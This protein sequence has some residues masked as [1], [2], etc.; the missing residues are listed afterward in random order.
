M[1]TSESRTVEFLDES[2]SH[3]VSVVIPS[4]DGRLTIRRALDSLIP[5][6]RWIREVILVFSNSPDEFQAFARTL[7][8]DYES[9]FCVHLIDSG[10]QSNGA[11][12]RN[13]G[14]QVAEAPLVALLDDDDEWFPSKLPLYLSVVVGER[15]SGDFVLFSQVVSCLDDRT[16]WLL[17]PSIRYRGEPIADF[18]FEPR[19][20]AQT[21]SLLLPTGLAQR[22]GF[23][24]SLVRHQDY[25]FCLRLEEAGAR[26][27]AIDR[28]LSFWYRRGSNLEKGATF[29][30][31]ANWIRSNV[32]RVSRRAYVAYIGKELLAATRAS[33]LWSRYAQFQREHLTLVER[34]ALLC[35]L[36]E[37]AVRA[38][39]R[40]LLPVRGGPYLPR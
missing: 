24:P 37:R 22:V 34:A 1:T 23:D 19:G 7:L 11:I 4:R 3:S 16:E 18:V 8:K 30:Y 21:S 33:G 10:P 14:I 36:T 9:H 26:F 29:D 28:P 31:C 32:G 27:H 20:G 38:A 25:D 39:L 15:L 2:A 17:F 5:G 13:A 12:A 35:R 40:R 6:A